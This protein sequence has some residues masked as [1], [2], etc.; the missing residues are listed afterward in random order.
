MRVTA[1]S[2]EAMYIGG[3][4]GGD[5]NGAGAA[6]PPARA[7]AIK[8]RQPRQSDRLVQSHQASKQRPQHWPNGSWSSKPAKSRSRSRERGRAYADPCPAPAP[9]PA[10][11]AAAMR[12]VILG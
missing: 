6:P 10:P 11:F 3:G 7:E 12:S 4:G 1:A 2:R 8:S 5:G 9:A